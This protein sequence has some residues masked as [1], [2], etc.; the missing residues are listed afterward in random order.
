VT[1]TRVV[2]GD[3]IEVNPPLSWTEDVR[4]LGVDTPE[5]V[6]PGEPVEPYGPEASA[7]TTQQLEGERVT[8]IFDQEKRDQYGRALA[9]VQISGQSVTFN[10]T[11]LKQGY[12][13]IYVV[14]PNDRYEVAFSQA[15]EQA[16]Q[17]QRGIWGLPKDQQCE[18]ADRGNGIGEGSPGC[19][20]RTPSPAPDPGVDKDCSD[21]Q[22]QA[23]AQAELERDPS[24]PNNLDGDGDGEACETYPYGSGSG[25]GGGGDLDCADFA[26][27]REAQVVLERDPSDP[28]G[29]DADN[30]G[31]ACEELA[32]GGGGGG[33]GELDCASF[34]TQREAQAELER[35]PSDPNNLDADGDGVACETYP[36]ATGGGGGEGG[37]DLNCANFATHGEA[38]REY[39]KD[40]TDPNNLDADNDGIA[41]EELI[42][43]GRDGSTPVGDQYEPKTPPGPVDRPEG[44]IPRTGVKRVPPTGGPPYLAV[45]AVVLLVAALIVGRGVLRR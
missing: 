45:G 3:T 40:R 19:Q 25:G 44:V 4:L 28:N 13:Q 26:T 15:Q 21:F 29:L 24:D 41:C 22:S 33:D 34:A 37:G 5:T 1:V 39:A 36:Y 20:G 30:D 23:A 35:N 6:D 11:L 14:A 9:Y 8:L 18:L 12:A 16:R 7:F 32:G 17:A 31:I 2:D 38:Q 10:E 27:Q 42:G 43:E